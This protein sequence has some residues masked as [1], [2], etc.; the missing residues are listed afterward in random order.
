M[1]TEKFGENICY[2]FQQNSFMNELSQ[3]VKTR[4][5]TDFSR[6]GISSY[7]T[8]RHP[9]GKWT[10]FKDYEKLPFGY[11]ENGC[12]WY[13]LFS[14]KNDDFETAKKKTENLLLASIKE[15]TKDMEKIAVTISGGVDS[16]LIAAM[17]RRIYP[18]KELY[19]Y[20]A[21]FY[22]DDEFEYARIVAEDNNFIHKEF[23][24]GKDAFLGDNSLLKALIEFKAAPLHPNELPLAF[25]E[26]EAKKD[27]MEIVLCGEGADDIF[28]GYGQNLRMY[29]NYEHKESFFKFLL[30]RYRY[31]NLE[32]RKIIKEE[33]LADDFELTLK[34]LNLGN[35]DHDIRNWAFYFTQV[36]H[37]PGLI[38]RGANAL[39]FN[40]L[41]LGF[42]YIDDELVNYVNSLPFEY[43]VA[44]KSEEARL[45]AI[46]KNYKEISEKYDIPK[47]ILKRLAESYLDDKIIYRPKKGFPVPFDLWL[48]DVNNWNLNSKVFKSNDIS[49]YNGWK[50]F[51]L[52]NLSTFCDIFED[53]L[54]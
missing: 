12:E 43:K 29:M 7:L 27:G 8:F 44:W 52:I 42:P 36:L 39:R 48:K 46:G 13:P 34:S 37:T 1:Q 10:M 5:F 3:M 23:R 50:K 24:L 4:G 38:T 15:L 6:E 30:D 49:S 16:S 21:G 20:C 9:I 35:L 47:M 31:F 45:K 19:S 25:I 41:P 11:S 22:G 14:K 26:K 54:Q 17:L 32:D 51:M 2:K 28:G 18:N 53:Y 33:Y 40:K